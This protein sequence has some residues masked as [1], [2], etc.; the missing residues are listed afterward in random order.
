MRK[1]LMRL[2]A[3]AAF[4]A[5]AVMVFVMLPQSADRVANVAE[6]VTMVETKT[7]SEVNLLV[8]IPNGAVEQGVVTQNVSLDVTVNLGTNLAG[9][10]SANVNA[11]ATNGNSMVANN[12][13]TDVNGL[14][15]S[16][17]TNPNASA[18][19][20]ILNTGTGVN[21]C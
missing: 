5:L 17:D 15:D 21:F 9:M 11:N 4:T 13:T 6:K 8:V 14:G 1:V 2:L 18:V 3:V 16:A 19:G 20:P 12:V 10:V 7:H